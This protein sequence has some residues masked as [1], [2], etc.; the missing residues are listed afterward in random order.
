MLK[1]D[2]SDNLEMLY[3]RWENFPLYHI[4]STCPQPKKVT[5]KNELGMTN[6]GVIALTES[7][8]ENSLKIAQ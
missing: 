8:S 6:W 2:K 7:I 4:A 3:P 5:N 1:E